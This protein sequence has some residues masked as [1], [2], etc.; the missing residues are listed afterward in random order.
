MA[1][2]SWAVTEALLG[3]T[4]EPDFTR[5]GT[6]CLAGWPCCLGRYKHVRLHEPRA[7]MPGQLLNCVRQRSICMALWGNEPGAATFRRARCGEQPPPKQGKSSRP[8]ADEG[9]Q[10]AGPA[11][12]WHECGR[13]REA[14]KEWLPGSQLCPAGRRSSATAEAHRAR[15]KRSGKSCASIYWAGS[16]SKRCGKTVGDGVTAA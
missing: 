16:D 6:P 12:S 9:Q 4:H 13:G 8:C 2:A 7:E 15:G 5:V 1:V 10:E 11:R 14:G 3:C